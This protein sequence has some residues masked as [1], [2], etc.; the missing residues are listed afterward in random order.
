RIGSE[1][2]L[3]SEIH[4]P[5]ASTVETLSEEGRVPVRRESHVGPRRRRPDR[6]ADRSPARYARPLVRHGAV[7]GALVLVLSGCTEEPVSRTLR[8][9]TGHESDTFT[10]A[11]AVTKVRVQATTATGTTFT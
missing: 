9:I 1:M 11:P 2:D 4:G 3:S 10:A 5:P 8:I 6:A 7:L